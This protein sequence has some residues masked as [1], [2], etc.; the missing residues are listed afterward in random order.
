MTSAAGT[1]TGESWTAAFAHA[2]RP[3]I[4]AARTEVAPPFDA[5]FAEQLGRRL[6]GIAA[7]TLVLELHRARGTLNGSTGSERF[8]DFTRT[9]D[10]SSVF[11]RYPVLARLLAQACEQAVSVHHELS[12]RFTRDRAEIVRELFG[13]L[14]PGALVAIETGQGDPHQQGRTVAI[15][16]FESGARLVYRPRPTGLHV[17]FIAQL[18]WLSTRTGIN[19]RSPR[20]LT[21]DGYGWLEHVEYEPCADVAGV[22]EFYRRL[23]ALLALLYAVDGTDMHYEN[24]IACGDQ[25]VLV[26]VETLFHPTPGASEDP[27]ALALA[28]SVYRTALLPHVLLGDNG[29]VDVG[30]VGGDRGAPSPLDVVDWADAGTDR[31]RLVRRPS[32][33]SG[34]FNRPLLH[35]IPAEPADYQDSL[36]AGFRASYDAI[37]AHRDELVRLVRACADDEVRFV[38]RATRQY[39]RLLDESTHPSVLADALDRDLAFGVLVVD[40][41]LL[42]R[43]VPFEVAD[44]WRGDVPLFTCRPGSRDLW[45]GSGLRLPGMLP[46]PGLLAVERKIAAMSE[47][48]RHDQQWVITAA[49]AS[50]PRPVSHHSAAPLSCGVAPVDPDPARL[51]VA[52][53]GIADQI[54]AHAVA[55]ENRVNW[56][57]LELVD[58][59]HWAVQPLGAGLSNGYTGVAL[60]LAELGA[61]T[62][63][64]RYVDFAVDA[65]RPLPALL[66]LFGSTPEL[67]SAA[68]GGLHGLGGICY[69]LARLTPLLGLDPALLSTAVSLMP[70]EDSSMSVVDG[71]AGSLAAMLAVGTR[72]SLA[73]AD[74]YAT[75]LRAAICSTNGFARGHAG[76]G[77]ALRR[78]AATVSNESTDV[79]GLAFLESDAID[80]TDS[81]WCSGLAGAALA[82]D[83]ERLAGLLAAREP[84]RDMSL[85]HGELGVVEALAAHHPSAA[86]RRTALLLGALDDH[87]PRCATPGGVPSPG[88]LTG[89]A[90]IGHGLLRQGFPVPSVLLLEPTQH[91][92]ECT[93]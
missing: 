78:Y 31:M 47:V 36:L 7:R 85:C 41:P 92:E 12:S 89:L 28:R 16:S 25:P 50:R 46:E 72:D 26:D 68:G 21:R 4:D 6:V 40:D 55:G 54:L 24:L 70:L 90:G 45:T 2:L 14:D 8:D 86:T 15:L 30:G 52:A 20:L 34:A 67:V 88:L 62:G 56:L 38:A 10:L 93:R 60:F 79:T 81:G 5:A 22:A 83:D 61:L 76:I 11:A 37:V 27:A 84:L 13:G 57:G 1:S 59:R 19:F 64:A 53:C 77:W 58:D 66:E 43:L 44:L 49:L 23:G 3:L 9:L 29:V 42:D 17:R 33:S 80:P 71:V 73:L 82:R 35:G 48:D 32:V 75:V 74:H 39:A 51:L 87:G 18:R 63:A 91:I 65:M 69:G